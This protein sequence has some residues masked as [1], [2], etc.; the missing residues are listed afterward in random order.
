MNIKTQGLKQLQAK[1]KKIKDVNK[2][3]DEATKDAAIWAQNKLI[4]TTPFDKISGLEH[5]KNMWEFPAKIEQSIYAI[6]NIKTSQ[7]GKYSIARILNDGRKEVKAKDGKK[8]F[9]P[10]SRK[11]KFKKIGEKI[12]KEWKRGSKKNMGDSNIDYVLADKS[13]K[14]KP[15]HFIDKVIKKTDKILIKSAIKKIKEVFK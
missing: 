12:P 5:T 10:F 4:E 15:T 7:N 2:F 13:K 11:A 8:L 14:V 6:D 9:I 1:L 3:F